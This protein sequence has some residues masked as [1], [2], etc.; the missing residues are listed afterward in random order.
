MHQADLNEVVPWSLKDLNAQGRMDGG[1]PPYVV[2][3]VVYIDD[4]GLCH[5]V[6]I[7]FA[8]FDSLQRAHNKVRVQASAPKFTHFAP[9]IPEELRYLFCILNETDIETLYT[10]FG[11]ILLL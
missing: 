4:V 5:I 2:A 9:D 11:G 1:K 3:V 8:V 7:A 6:D 10:C